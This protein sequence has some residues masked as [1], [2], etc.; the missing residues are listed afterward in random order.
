MKITDGTD[1]FLDGGEIAAA[2]LGHDQIILDGGNTPGG[3]HKQKKHS[4]F[5]SEKGGCHSD[6][7]CTNFC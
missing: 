4:G 5:H 3:K 6:Y 7:K 2:I 1:G